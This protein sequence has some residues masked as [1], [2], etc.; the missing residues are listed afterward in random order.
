MFWSAI[1]VGFWA[2]R[3]LI[4][5]GSKICKMYNEPQEALRACIIIKR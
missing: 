1:K 4:G 5:V 3:S 2:I